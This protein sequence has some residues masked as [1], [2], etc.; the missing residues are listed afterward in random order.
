[1][2]PTPNKPPLEM[3]IGQMFERL[4]LVMEKA[5]PE[6]R[7]KFKKGWLDSVHRF[8]AETERMRLERLWRL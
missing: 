6:E 4:T 7:Q 2:K 3:T 1:M 8:N 5:T